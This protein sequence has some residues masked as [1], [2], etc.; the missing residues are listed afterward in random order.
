MKGE[1]EKER[2]RERM[3]VAVAAAAAVASSSRRRYIPFHHFDQVCIDRYRDCHRLA[4][5]HI[6]FRS[7]VQKRYRCEKNYMK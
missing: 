2:E 7:A 3:L 1:R 4:Y 5:T 6:T